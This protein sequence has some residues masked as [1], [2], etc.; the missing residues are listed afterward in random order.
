L[1]VLSSTLHD[2]ALPIDHLKKLNDRLKRFYDHFKMGT[3]E[4]IFNFPSVSI[5]KASGYFRNMDI[6]FNAGVEF[7]HN[8]D[9]PTYQLDETRKHSPYFLRALYTGWETRNHGVI[10]S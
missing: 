4:L 8:S 3:S 1:W 5:A 9:D 6:V 2:I 10:A 7:N